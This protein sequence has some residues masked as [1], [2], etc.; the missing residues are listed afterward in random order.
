MFI[1]S[2][3]PVNIC[4][5]VIGIKVWMSE[6]DEHEM[7][8]RDMWCFCSEWDCFV[9]FASSSVDVLIRIEDESASFLAVLLRA[10]TQEA[11]RC[12]EICYFNKRMVFL[13]VVGEWWRDYSS[14]T[15]NEDLIFFFWI[16]IFLSQLLNCH[17]LPVSWN[18]ER[19]NSFV[20]WWNTT[21]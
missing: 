7:M 10:R 11:Q 16:Q 17:S 15:Y 12:I 5:W 9:G 19:R 3:V 14:F 2:I 21:T 6:W 8:K 4:M 13:S 1:T 18:F 20:W